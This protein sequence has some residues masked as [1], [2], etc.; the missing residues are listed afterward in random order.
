MPQ[1][2]LLQKRSKRIKNRHSRTNRTLPD[3]VRF[4]PGQTGHIPLG[5]SGVRLVCPG[6]GN[7]RVKTLQGQK[8]NCCYCGK[9]FQPDPPRRRVCPVCVS[10]RPAHLRERRDTVGAMA[11]RAERERERRDRQDQTRHSQKRMAAPAA[12]FPF[13]SVG[14]KPDRDTAAA[15]WRERNV[16]PFP[17]GRL[18]RTETRFWPSGGDSAA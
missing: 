5:M 18:K 10:R 16:I 3:I 1:C 6:I 17:G 11:A 12:A 8:M 7:V 15:A 2:F 13:V 14:S 4:V 9:T